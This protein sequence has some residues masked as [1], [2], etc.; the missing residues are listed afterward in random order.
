MNSK[1]KNKNDQPISYPRP[2]PADEQ[3]KNQPEFLD[4][5]PNSFQNEVSDKPAGESSS[6]TDDEK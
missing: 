1:D 3:L 5:E 2:S 4:G 6:E